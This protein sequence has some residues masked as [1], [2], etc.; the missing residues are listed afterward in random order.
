MIPQLPGGHEIGRTLQC[1][2]RFL[3]ELCT[4]IP[5]LC[6]GILPILVAWGTR[7]GRFDAPVQDCEDDVGLDVVRT[8]WDIDRASCVVL[9]LDLRGAAASDRPR[10]EET[11]EEAM[12]I[13]SLCASGTAD[14]LVEIPVE[15]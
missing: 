7:L 15:Q 1:S 14:A 8:A 6:C 11:S 2:H 13:G 12:S 4:F 5:L 10:R 9:E 3:I